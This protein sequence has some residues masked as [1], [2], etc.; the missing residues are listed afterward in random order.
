MAAAGTKSR[1]MRAMVSKTFLMQ[2]YQVRNHQLTKYC[3]CIHQLHSDILIGGGGS[4][5]YL[6]GNDGNDLAIGDCA[7]IVFTSHYFLESIT[8]TFPSVGMADVIMMGD[9]NDL[10]IGGSGN[11]TIDGHNGTNILLGDSALILFYGT[12]LD[13]G[14]SPEAE[15]F[16][17]VPQSV[18]TIYCEYGDEDAIYGGNGTD[19]IMGG[20]LG[21]EVH[22]HGGADLV[23][24][25]HGKLVLYEDPPYKLMNVTTAYAACTPGQDKIYLGDG[26]DIAFGGALGDT[27]DG[28]A[29]QDIILG[30]FGLYRDQVHFLPNQFFESITD[31]DDFAGPDTIDGGPDD[32]IILGQ[33]SDDTIDG[34]SG[35]DDLYGG[36]SKRF[37]E[38]LL[39]LP[40]CYKLINAICSYYFTPPSLPQARILMILCEGETMMM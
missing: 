9:G 30:D 27:I 7:S 40:N 29:G 23:L 6:E 18:E 39:C 35:S 14:S 10:A 16:W 15:N 24:G 37:G 34:G 38:L 19:Y 3:S 26:P 1:V 22:A 32:D 33:E 2:S 21:D 17:G 31:H 12:E 36:H 13:A 20:S 4:T 8:S 5:N 11:D 25:D 28:G